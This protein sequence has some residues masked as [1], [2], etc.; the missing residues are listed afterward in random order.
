MRQL[1]FFTTK[2]LA[3]MR[4]RTASRGY[5]PAG[6]EFRRVHERHRS[7]GLIQRHARTLRR[8]RADKSQTAPAAVVTADRP[9]G[10]CKDRPT[11]AP[12]DL[13]PVEPAPRPAVS[14]KPAASRDLL[15]NDRDQSR[16]HSPAAIVWSSSVGLCGRHR[17]GRHGLHGR[18]RHALCRLSGSSRRAL[19]RH[20][21]RWS[22]RE[23]S[24]RL[25]RQHPG[26][27]ARCRGAPSGKGWAGLSG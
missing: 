18:G 19:G 6:E 5:S 1:Q 15:R 25:Q 14:A 7:W 26:S 23:H 17:L 2:E 12:A 27:S 16:R 9:E 24:A 3:A 21:C 13:M 10:Q 20:P 11:P 8:N 4:D 22:M